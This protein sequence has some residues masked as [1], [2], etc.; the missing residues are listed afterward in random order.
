MDLPQT[1][2]AW[3]A[4]SL[5]LA[6]AIALDRRPYAPGKRNYVPLMMVTLVAW[7]VLT[8]HLARLVLAGG[9]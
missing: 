3:I 7:M 4:V 1:L 9:R 5:V 2:A 6:A 8:G